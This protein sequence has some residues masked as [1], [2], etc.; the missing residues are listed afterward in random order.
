MSNKTSS[1]LI[2]RCKWFNNKAGYGFLT[3]V[4]TDDDTLLGKDIFAHHSAIVVSSEQYKY[5]VQGE[6]VSFEIEDMESHKDTDHSVQASDITG[7]GRG[8]LMCETR[9]EM[10][11]LQEQNR[12]HT[13]DADQPRRH[14]ARP[15]R[16]RH[17]NQVRLKGEGPRDGEAWTHTQTQTDNNSSG[18]TE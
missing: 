12:S 3:V 10:R 8:P 15:S 5:L 11:K 9:H 16:K 7:V 14:N 2:G 1:T 13:S 18:D 6:Y 17:T 4:Q